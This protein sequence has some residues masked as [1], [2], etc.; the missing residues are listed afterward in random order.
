MDPKQRVGF[1][2]LKTEQFVLKGGCLLHEENLKKKIIFY[3]IFTFK[4]AGDFAN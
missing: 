1:R 3:Y 4:G 2:A